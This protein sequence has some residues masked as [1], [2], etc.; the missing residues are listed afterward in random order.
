MI[1]YYLDELHIIIQFESVCLCKSMFPSKDIMLIL[2]SS[3]KYKRAP[4]ASKQ[5]WKTPAIN[6]KTLIDSFLCYSKYLH[7]KACIIQKQPPKGVPCKANL[8]KPHFGMG[9]PLKIC[10]I[11]SDHLFLGTPQVADSNHIYI[12]AILLPNYSFLSKIAILSYSPL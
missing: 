10:C 4:S 3:L 7:K 11:F 12:K 2:K 6:V 1:C 5:Y 9:V 8:L